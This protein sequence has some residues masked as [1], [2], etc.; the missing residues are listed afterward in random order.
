MVKP[1]FSLILTINHNNTDYRRLIKQAQF[2]DYQNLE[3]IIVSNRLNTK[4]QHIVDF[5]AF[6]DNLKRSK[7]L[8]FLKRDS[9]S[10][11][12]NEGIL[13]ATGNYAWCIDENTILGDKST[14]TKIAEKIIQSKA[15][16]IYLRKKAASSNKNRSGFSS[17]LKDP[18]LDHPVSLVSQQDWH[19]HSRL[20][21]NLESIRLFNIHFSEGWSHAHGALLSLQIIRFFPNIYHYSQDLVVFKR[22]N[23]RISSHA[24][25][26]HILSLN[27]ILRYAEL[28]FGNQSDTFKLILKR[29]IKDN[30]SV[31][32]SINA[33]SLNDKIK[34]YLKYSRKVYLEYYINKLPKS[35]S[36]I[37][38]MFSSIKELDTDINTKPSEMLREFFAS[39]RIKVH[40]G[41]H[42]TATT[43]VQSILNEARYDLALQ[44]TIYAHH[45]QLR[46]DFAIAKQQEGII[47]ERER[48]AFAICKQS[49]ILSFKLPSILIISEENLIRPNISSLSKWDSKETYQNASNYSCACIR[50]GYDLDHLKNVAQ[51]FQ[52]GIETIYTVR[53]Y[54]DYLL[55]RH[56]EFLKWRSFKEF[57]EDFIDESDLQKCDWRYII[58]DLHKIS[59]PTSIIA[60]ESF[61]SNPMKFAN[62]LAG[63]NLSNYKDYVEEDQSVSRSRCSQAL[64][65]NLANKKNVGIDPMNIKNIFRNKIESISPSDPKFSSKLRSDERVKEVNS[66]YKS[67]YLSTDLNHFA[68]NSY[69]S[70]A[71]KYSSDYNL[72]NKLPLP[73][74]AELS[75]DRQSQEL[76]AYLTNIEERSL[77]L[78]NRFKSRSI[79]HGISAM[80][81]IK[82]EGSNIYNVLTSIKNCFDEIVV[83]DNNS[84][85]NTISEIDR[86]TKDFSILKNKLKLYHYKF[87]ISKCG[88]DN[89]REPQN[90][91]NSLASFY[92]YSLKKCSFSKICKWD[93]DMILPRSMEKS[94][95][96]FTKK[97]LSTTASRKDSTIFGVMKGITVYKGSNSKFYC[98]PSASEREARIF[99][100]SPG[101][102]FV[103]DILWEQ[104]FSL[105]NIERIISEDLTFV[106]FKDTST[107]EFSHWSIAASLGMS[108]RKS[109]ELR[110]FNLIKKITQYQNSE[111][112][113]KALLENGFQEAHF[114]VFDFSESRSL[115]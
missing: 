21:I 93:G 115:C 44:N 4:D 69:S 59:G 83:I 16:A 45:E 54:F 72:S 61:K 71:D 99:D 112:M 64:L 60:F 12:Y 101:V 63:F 106:E 57:D 15:Q 1:K 55:S 95:K 6:N 22:S 28:I 53:N 8:S 5:L 50:N 67:T 65:D 58:S 19:N 68:N 46:E 52:G 78:E 41:A 36:E 2:Q 104:L 3:I 79:G 108:P 94:F 75:L 33:S 9:V 34:D 14:I 56:S 26:T 18:P 114:D 113:N 90:S 81:R 98:R 74:R 111:E 103:K 110:D 84:S 38:N 96:N 24:F 70:L 87:E 10:S 35:D 85:D 23:S 27:Y 100:N 88:I 43:Y 107:N 80:I 30:K 20:V 29:E 48:L 77:F 17:Q 32:Q 42:K 76:K 51:I 109:R 47:D 40:C 73:Q 92:N 89:F 7:H 82:N 13:H 39:S 49:A 11:L 62:Y 86:A 37:A 102:F 66:A 97:I 25:V 105:H 31:F 91:P